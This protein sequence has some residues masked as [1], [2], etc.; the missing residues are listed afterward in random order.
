MSD[1]KVSVIVPVYNIRAFAGDCIRSLLAQTMKGVE[2]LIVDDASTDGS[3]EIVKEL[4][5][6]N[7]D[8][9]L[10]RHE[11]NMGLPAARNTGLRAARGEY[12]I[13]C[14]GDDFMAPEM[15][16]RLY[17]CAVSQKADMVWCDWYL[18]FAGSERYM[19]QPSC[20]TGREAVAGML[21]GRMK[22]NVWNKLCRRSLYDGLQFPEGRSMGEDMTMIKVAAKA[23]RTA[24]VAEALY[25]YR[26]TNAEALTQNYSPRK[27][28][29]LMANTLD[30]VAFLRAGGEVSELD[31]N[32][33]LLNVKL[34]FL[35]TGK[36]EDIKRWRQ[37]F[38]E[39]DRA[40]MAN[41]D[42]SL[43]VR[44]LEWSASKGFGFVN[45]LYYN[46]VQKVIYGKIYR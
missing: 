42:Q 14:D 12:V 6:D 4:I 44:L 24:H 32:R 39:A 22:Y 31:I 36:S 19:K 21:S 7:P 17:D 41:K 3:F 45:L 28:N 33:F 18:S 8:F 27:L 26:R 13:H 2:Y 34:P 46:L 5:G 35:F 9:R 40:I 11:R 23:K 16:E 15:V 38:K 10:L 37:W 43:R 20:L 29:E 1:F 30:I 25:H